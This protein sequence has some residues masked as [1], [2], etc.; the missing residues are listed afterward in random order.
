MGNEHKHKFSA[1]ILA[2]G[3]GT[4]MRSRLPKV[5]HRLAGQ[6][7]LAHVLGAVAPLKPEHAVVVVA[8]GME[9]VESAALAASPR[10]KIAVQKKQSGTGNAVASALP[11]LKH[12]AGTV[13]VLYGDTPMISTE[14]LGALLMQHNKHKAAISLLGMRP[15]SPLGYGRLVMKKPPYVERIVECRDA[16]AKE[17]KI[18]DVWAGVMAFD[19]GFLREGL[20][21][22]KPS[23]T[24]GEYYLTA[25]IEMA[26][27]KKLRTLMVPVAVEEAMGVNSRAQLA[28]AE[29][30]MQQRLR[31]RAME[32][33]ATLVAPETIFLCADTK[34]GSDVTLHP[35]IIFGPGVSVADDVEIRSFSHIEGASIASQAVVGP[36]ARLRPGTVVGKGAHVGNFVELKKATLGR[37]AKA[38]HLSYIG[39]AEIG[40]R[41][42]IGAGTITCNY[43]GVAHKYKTVVG[44][45]AAIGSN[46]SLVAPVTV[47]AGAIVGAGSVITQDV[48]A[49]AMAVARAAQ[50]NK[51]GGGK[52]FRQKRGKK[53]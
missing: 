25:L 30:A 18:A 46:T 21:Q 13:L 51:A 11:L 17:K 35:Y 50:V 49:D 43:D 47:G 22:L 16:N 42:N 8:P 5:L 20:A 45:D 44:E 40:A 15:H 48:P 6:P 33:G 29:H 12:Y 28:E 3:A 53:G 27:A 23:K 26:S 24:T 19:A 14:T 38:N 37:G 4:R 34:L 39:D 31:A 2:A 9:A 41:A 1:L 36:Y 32:N 7:M 10:V 52:R